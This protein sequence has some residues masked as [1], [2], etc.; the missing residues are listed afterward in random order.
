MAT[1][2]F[3]T[4]HVATLNEAYAQSTNGLTLITSQVPVPSGLTLGPHQ[5]LFVSD[6]SGGDVYQLLTTGALRFKAGGFESPRDIA[7]DPSGNL[8]VADAA[9]NKVYRLDRHG[10][11]TVIADNL[12]SPCCLAFDASGNLLVS[13]FLAAAD[14]G[15]PYNGAITRI[16][17]VG[18]QTLIASGFLDPQGLLVDHENTIVI[19]AEGY[20][21]FQGTNVAA[22]IGSGIFKIDELGQVTRILDVGSIS[23]SGLALSSQGSLF[24][25][26]VTSQE[27]AVFVSGG[28][29]FEPFVTGLTQPRGLAVDKKSLYVADEKAGEVWRVNLKNHGTNLVGGVSSAGTT[30]ST[31]NAENNQSPTENFSPA[32]PVDPTVARQFEEMWGYHGKPDYSK[33]PVTPEGIPQAPAGVTC[34]IGRVV[35]DSYWALQYVT[36]RL[37]RK[38]IRTN[39]TGYWMLV[40]VPSGYQVYMLDGRSGDSQD[41]HYPIALVGQWLFQNQA[42][43]LP[44]GAYLPVLDS[45]HTTH[46]DPNRETIHTTPLI[47]GLEIHIPA[48]TTITSVDG[49]PVT[50]ITTTRVP[51]GKPIYPMTLVEDFGNHFTLQPGGAVSSKNVRVLYNNPLK[52]PAGTRTQLWEYSPLLHGGW[53]E[54]GVGTVSTNGSQIVPDGGIGFT[55]FGCG[56]GN[57]NP[58]PPACSPDDGV[59]DNGGDLVTLGTGV[60]QQ[61]TPDIVIPGLM[62]ID[63]TRN[64]RSQDNNQYDFGIGTQHSF[65]YRL[66]GTASLTNTGSYIDFTLPNDNSYRFVYETNTTQFNFQY[67]CTNDHRF[68]GAVIYQVYNVYP[69]NPYPSLDGWNYFAVMKNGT[70][71]DFDGKGYLCA[72]HDANNNTIIIYRGPPSE[73]LGGPILS[74]TQPSGRS[75]SFS[76]NGTLIS[77]V[78]DS[79]GR[80]LKYFY[81]SSNRLTTVTNIIG[82]ATQY[83]YD[84]SNNMTSVTLPNNVR[85]SLV[86]YDS[87]NRATN[88]VVADNGVYS[89][90]YLTNVSNGAITRTT[91]TGPQGGT[92]TYSYLSLFLTNNPNVSAQF[93]TNVVDSLGNTN[94]Y[95]RGNRGELLKSI[96]PLGRTNTILYDL[97]YNILAVTN[98][99]GKSTS[100]T[101]ETNLNRVTS[102]VDANGHTN[103]FGYNGLVNLTSV[104]SA[105][106]NVSRIA[107]TPL[108][109]PISITDPLG[110]TYTLTYNGI[111]DLVSITDPLGN[112]ITRVLDS[113]GRP[114]GMIDPFGRATKIVYGDQLG[115][116]MSCGSAAVDLPISITDPAGGVTSFKYDAVGN[117]TNVTDALGHVVGYGYDAMNRLTNRTDQLNRVETY[118]YDQDGN[119]TNFVDRRGMSITFNY[120]ILDRRTAVMYAAGDSVSY[121]Y[122]NV[123]RVTNLLDSITGSTKLMYDTL[124]RLT[125]VIDINGTITYSY[126]NASLRTNMTVAGQN[127]VAY[128]YDDGNRLTN[129]VQGTFTSSLSYDD[130]GRRTKLVLPNG[131]NTLY[132]YDAVSRLTS[133]VYQASSTNALG[134]TYDQVGNRCSQVSAL[135]IYNLPS[136]ISH[137]TYD[138][139]NHQLTF[140]SYNLLYDLDG[141]VT[142]IANGAITN[143]LLWSARNQLTNMLGAVVA[144]FAYDGL[145]RR[146]TRTVNSNTEKYLY[147]GLDIIQQLNNTGTIGAN[148]FRS[149][150]IDEPW[151]RSDVGAP[152]TNRIYE[153]DALGSIVALTD[154]NQGIQTQYSYDPF[155]GTTNSGVG[156]K[157]SYEFVG[158]END[159]TG[160][161]YY[162]ARYYHSTLGRFVSEDPI[163]LGGGSVNF[164]SYVGNNPTYFLDPLGLDITIKLYQGNTPFGHIGI[165]VNSPDTWGFYPMNESLGSVCQLLKGGSVAGQV[166]PDIAAAIHGNVGTLVITTLPWQD[167]AV[168]NYIDSQRLFP[169]NYALFGKRKCD[170][171]SFVGQALNAGGIASPIIILPNNLF[172]DLLSISKMTNPLTYLPSGGINAPPP[173]VSGG[174]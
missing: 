161:Y 19:A 62:P 155:G 169:G 40:D 122:D 9:A 149:L 87:Y 54:Y 28:G 90:S 174:G 152:N 115:G 146:I 67:I 85:K 79:T 103:I 173:I 109:L 31:A 15:S 70:R 20:F 140:G 47:P 25:S 125:Q 141:N 94:A 128:F 22:V 165:G 129:V 3:A 117:L 6:S 73:S 82:G 157:N 120:D 108:G 84:A 135:S 100:F 26:G 118:R 98:T 136:A 2:L 119:V 111:A 131:I 60:F 48:H 121:L 23:P 66:Y 127:V 145:G 91:I 27:G 156:S 71:Y 101:Y 89:F 39:S 150:G 12:T 96:D 30:S 93:V 162:R 72:I 80:S 10:D 78:T 16:S 77:S 138:A 52:F 69:Y 1:G 153:A 4:F 24:F 29:T 113:L 171:A 45:A 151:Q 44:Y 76:Y 11:S 170:C 110:N 168:Q 144:T 38:A 13:H 65:D 32:G 139:A 61:D 132:N 143:E 53:Y 7:F 106:G 130:D 58:P 133:I 92:A 148:Y 95:I 104:T 17:P 68:A 21:D 134:Y 166:R 114:V 167:R 163:E 112:R 123:S 64:Y 81:D 154:T 107:Y 42:N 37:G 99:Q 18:Q 51:V 56:L 158:R 116:C 59:S 74:I 142:N 97:N 164:Y 46:I 86:F 172:N 36:V 43:V 57:R 63:L 41:T 5:M 14:E 8:Y 124:D 34:V 35:D 105:L 55:T 83:T 159:I 137:S 102:I 49:L 75:L 88:E 33:I 126:N 147:D 160:L 50:E